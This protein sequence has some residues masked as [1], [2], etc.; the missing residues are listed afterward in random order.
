VLDGRLADAPAFTRGIGR[1]LAP[2]ADATTLARA[3]DLP[4]TVILF[5]GEDG[6][7][8]RA[9]EG[10]RPGCAPISFPG[11]PV[12][13]VPEGFARSC[14]ALLGADARGEHELAVDTIEVMFWPFD[15]AKLPPVPWP[16]DLPAPPE[17]PRDGTDM[18]HWFL[19]GRHL[20]RIR[21]FRAGLDPHQAVG[22]RGRK[23]SSSVRLVLPGDRYL[24]KVDEAAR[25]A[26]FQRRRRAGEP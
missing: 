20:A 16:A 4:V 12:D 5:R 23:W 22:F 14:R 10:V 3:T 7:I 19:P 17:A 8:R 1:D 2:V 9:V 13:P 6:W 15:H 18:I 21:A 26:S 25:R 11:I 24:T